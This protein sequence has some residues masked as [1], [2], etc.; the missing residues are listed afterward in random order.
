MTPQ[1]NLLLY[2]I[3]IVFK[4]NTVVVVVMR[5]RAKLV[6]AEKRRCDC[7]AHWLSTKHKKRGG[8]ESK[9]HSSLFPNRN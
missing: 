8:W 9:L 7:R 4:W 2:T 6:F 1:A 3:E 5:T